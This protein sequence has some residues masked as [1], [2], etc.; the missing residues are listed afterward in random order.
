MLRLFTIAAFLITLLVPLTVLAQDDYAA[1]APGEL[2]ELR[3]DDARCPE[4]YRCFTVGRALP[5]H[6][7]SPQDIVD[8]VNADLDESRQ[9]SME[10][11]EAANQCRIIYRLGNGSYLRNGICPTVNGT[12]ERITYADVRDS[13]STRWL[14]ASNSD[15]LTIYRVPA[16][17]HLTPG[18]RAEE[19][20]RTLDAAPVAE[21]VP[22]PAQLGSWLVE[23]AD[24]MGAEQPPSIEQVRSVIEAAGRTLVRSNAEHA[25]TA[26]PSSVSAT[27]AADHDLTSEEAVTPSDD[28]VL[29]PTTADGIPSTFSST[30]PAAA[31]PLESNPYFYLWLLIALLSGAGATYLIMDIV[32]WPRR[33]KQIAIEEG[34]R[35]QNTIIEAQ[36]KVKEFMDIWNTKMGNITYSKKVFLALLESY[37]KFKNAPPPEAPEPKVVYRD[38]PVVHLRDEVA[39]GAAKQ[40]QALAEA[41]VISLTSEHDAK[42]KAKDAEIDEWKS[43]AKKAEGDLIELKSSAE[44]AM[45]RFH[46]E[47]FVNLGLGISNASRITDDSQPSLM[48]AMELVH[49]VATRFKD[50][51]SGVYNTL[52]SLLAPDLAFVLPVSEPLVGAAPAVSE[53]MVSRADSTDSW[54]GDLDESVPD[55]ARERTESG[56]KIPGFG[57]IPALIAD[58]P[59]SVPPK[60]DESRIPSAESLTGEATH[61]GVR[62]PERP[63]EAGFSDDV[64]FR[65]SQHALP[66]NR[67]GRAKRKRDRKTTDSYDRSQVRTEVDGEKP[68]PRE[69]EKTAIID[70]A[71]LDRKRLEARTGKTLTPPSFGAATTDPGFEPDPTEAVKHSDLK[72]D[73]P[74][75]LSIF[76]D[77]ETGDSVTRKRVV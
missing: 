33:A 10:Q 41:R 63:P 55:L 27:D 36:G 76:D 64:P 44:D 49:T 39:I 38:A 24:L 22:A 56:V 5:G 65:P 46:A 45:R 12:S 32:F 15:F 7:V 67:G 47:F 17:R 25:S 71:A 29:Q 48:R 68:S 59:A 23:L 13:G 52:C 40:A 18:E 20:V 61:P 9:V 51:E 60:G 77:L 37:E 58:E 26:A 66:P 57:S 16:E 70:Q 28:S 53:P 72:K 43:K 35:Q 2:M 4:G 6:S 3:S 21:T 14:V 73:A 75:S 54:F 62:P 42:L 11:F 19:M 34:T 30:N 69:D 74:A 1:P 8:R 50:V 31:T